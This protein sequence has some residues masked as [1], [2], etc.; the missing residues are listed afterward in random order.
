[1]ERRTGECLGWDRACSQCNLSCPCAVSP[2]ELEAGGDRGQ[3]GLMESCQRGVLG[4][5]AS[6]KLAETGETGLLAASEHEG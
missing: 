1:M 6:S 2:L 3:H 4:G 5:V